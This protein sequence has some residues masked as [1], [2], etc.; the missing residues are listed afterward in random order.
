MNIATTFPEA[1]TGSTS[2]DG[3]PAAFGVTALSSPSAI[4]PA[5]QSRPSGL[6]STGAAELLRSHRRELERV[7][8]INSDRC[9]T[10]SARKWLARVEADLRR[11]P[12]EAPTLAGRWGPN[13]YGP[14]IAD[15]VKD[16]DFF[17]GLNAQTGRMG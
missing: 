7:I 5:S 14:T 9:N 6:Q 15:I 1:F 16:C 2:K 4:E 12:E 10:A 3:A 8:A 17:V 13:G 11:S